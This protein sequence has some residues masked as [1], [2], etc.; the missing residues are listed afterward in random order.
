MFQ[1]GNGDLI[2]C[3]E[4]NVIRRSGTYLDTPAYFNP[5]YSENTESFLMLNGNDNE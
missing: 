5:K 1:F 2:I 4:A 3:N